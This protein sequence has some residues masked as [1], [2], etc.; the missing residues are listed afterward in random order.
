MGITPSWPKLGSPQVDPNGDCPKLTQ[1]GTT[2][3]RSPQ[4]GPKWDHP[5]LVY[6]SGPKLGSPQVYPNWDHPQA[7]PNWNHPE[8]VTPTWVS[9]FIKIIVDLAYIEGF[10]SGPKLGSPQVIQNF[11]QM[12]ITSS[13]H[14]LG[15]PQ[16]DP[17]WDYPKLV[18][19]TQV[20]IPGWPKLG[21]PQVDPNWD[22]PK[23]TQIGITPSW[24]KMG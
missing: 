2:Q 3:I 12:W 19:P 13:W 4:V 8:L 14:N 24:A 21:S 22:H 1:I 20:G 16:V 7:D 10:P 18:T 15:S 6:P 5:K 11:T 9:G 23:L 17:N